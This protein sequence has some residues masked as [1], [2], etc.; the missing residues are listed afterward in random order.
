MVQKITHLFKRRVYLP[1]IPQKA[2]IRIW[3]PPQRHFHIE[4]MAMQAAIFRGT[5]T[6]MMGGVE[7]ETLGE[8]DHGP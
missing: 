3:F 2:G 7:A 8:F 5:G 4:R 1:E 6:Q